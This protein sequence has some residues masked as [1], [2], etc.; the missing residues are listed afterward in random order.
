MYRCDFFL[1]VCGERLIVRSTNIILKSIEILANYPLFMSFQC[2]GFM[3]RLEV[4][5]GWSLLYDYSSD[6]LMVSRSLIGLQVLL[7]PSYM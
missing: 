2:F 4:C 6:N 1:G 3:G 5:I 7:M